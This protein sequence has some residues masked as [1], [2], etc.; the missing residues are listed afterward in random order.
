[1]KI[2]ITMTLF[3]LALFTGADPVRA[4]EAIST[5]PGD[6]L[7]APASGLVIGR[8]TQIDGQSLLVKEEGEAPV[9]VHMT[10]ET[11]SPGNLQVGDQ[12]MVSLLED[13]RAAVITKGQIEA[14]VSVLDEGGREAR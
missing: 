9:R 12:V 7:S 13:G 4:A 2:F 14:E 5:L 6:K 1:M 10:A 11:V 8:I 3:L